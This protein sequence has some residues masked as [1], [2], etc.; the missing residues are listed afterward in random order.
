MHID[1]TLCV[2]EPGQPTFSIPTRR[3]VLD[4]SC[5]IVIEID[6]DQPHKV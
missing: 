5:S 4:K 6:P 1:S 2:L 3:L